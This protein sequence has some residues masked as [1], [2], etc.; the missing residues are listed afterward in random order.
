MRLNDYRPI[1]RNPILQHPGV[2][3]VHHLRIIHVAAVFKGRAGCKQQ[4]RQ[5][6]KDEGRFHGS[7]IKAEP[8][9]VSIPEPLPAKDKRT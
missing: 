7:Q 6:E 8:C 5:C 4:R 9:R 3:A 1:P 2:R